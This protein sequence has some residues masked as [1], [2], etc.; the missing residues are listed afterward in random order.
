MK[1]ILVTNH[2]VHLQEIVIGESVL[3]LGA[4]FS[5]LSN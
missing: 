1:Q 3:M 2:I 4:N 5:I